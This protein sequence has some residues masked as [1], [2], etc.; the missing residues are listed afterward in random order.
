MA[1]VIAKQTNAMSEESVGPID[2]GLE[3]GVASVRLLIEHIRQMAK[4]LKAHRL[5]LYLNGKKA[6]LSLCY[7]HFHAAPGNSIGSSVRI[8]ACRSRSWS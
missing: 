8:D 6:H 3:S 2:P 1:L 4:G 7:R 5:S